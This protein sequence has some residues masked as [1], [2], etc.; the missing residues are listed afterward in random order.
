MR[1]GKIREHNK[2]N[3]QTDRERE[4]ERGNVI[5]REWKNRAL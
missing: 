5:E 1:E 2:R 3:R 4:R